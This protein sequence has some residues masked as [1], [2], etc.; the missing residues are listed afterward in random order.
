MRNFMAPIGLGRHLMS[1]T[2]LLFVLAATTSAY[3]IIMRGG[4]RIEIPAQFTVT[5]AT[6]SYEAAPGFWV[7]LQLAAV[8]VPATERANNEMPGSLLF[9]ATRDKEPPRTSEATSQ[10]GGSRA[11]RTVTNRDLESFQRSRLQSEREYEQRLK[12]QGLPPLAVLRAQAAAE[13]ERFSQELARQQAESEAAERAAQLQSQIAALRAQLSYLQSSGDESSVF[14]EA[15]TVYGGVPFFGGRSR[16]NR[17]LFRVPFGVQIGGA[18]G[19]FHVPFGAPSR[20]GGFR[21]N[22]IVAPGVRS[23]GRGGFGGRPHGSPRNH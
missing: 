18:F 11:S 9:R 19:T 1:A 4:K 6:L 14:P 22:I 5:N 10:A 21:R 20:F 12:D 2:C 3:S 15:F 8:D 16:V 7:T 13:L 17:S 23:G